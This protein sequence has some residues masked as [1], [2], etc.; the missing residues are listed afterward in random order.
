CDIANGTSEDTDD[1]GIP[2]ECDSTCP[3]DADGDGDSDVDDILLA[4]GNFGGSGGGDVD[5]NGIIDVNDLLQ[6][7]AYFNGC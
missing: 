7:L 5:G 3:G 6:I 1:N 2:D 4:L